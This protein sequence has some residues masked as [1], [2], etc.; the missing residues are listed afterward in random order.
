M[1][2][3]AL[4]QIF[5]ESFNLS[6]VVVLLSVAFWSLL[7]GYVGAI[8][9]VPLLV[10]ARITCLHLEVRPTLTFDYDYGVAIHIMLLSC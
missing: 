5:G 4:L 2:A 7:W 6:A 9:S 10:C 3:H 8:L 1:H